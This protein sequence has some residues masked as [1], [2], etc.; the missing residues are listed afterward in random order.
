MRFPDGR[1]RDRSTSCRRRTVSRPRVSMMSAWTEAELSSIGKAE[2]VQVA[3]LRPD[4]GLGKEVTVWAVRSGDGIYVR[5]AVKGYG[6][7][8]YRGVEQTHYGRMRAVGIRKD[9]EL[10]D[11]DDQVNDEVDAAY[12]AKYRRYAGRILES[13]LTPQARSTTLRIMPRSTP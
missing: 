8:W 4:G 7:S 11:V 6:A 2:E 13:C 1:R 5:S 9:V 10:V 12:R 3:P